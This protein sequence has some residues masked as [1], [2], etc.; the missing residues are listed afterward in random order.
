MEFM[1]KLVDCRTRRSTEEVN[2]VVRLVS[3]SEDN[4]RS[5]WN[6]IAASTTGT[7]ADSDADEYDSIRFHHN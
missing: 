2:K 3:L 7:D 1:R 6:V 5:Q 4:L